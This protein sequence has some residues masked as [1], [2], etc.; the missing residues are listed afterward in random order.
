MRGP[1]ALFLLYG[2]ERHSLSAFQC[3]MS[4]HFDGSKVDKDV[5]TTVA[6]DETVAFGVLK[7]LDRPELPITQ[8]RSPPMEQHILFQARR[9]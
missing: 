4:I 6:S 2:G 1:W 8:G 9:Q 5:A 7:P 3:S